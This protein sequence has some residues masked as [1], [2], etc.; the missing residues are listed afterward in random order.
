MHIHGRIIGVHYCWFPAL[1]KKKAMFSVPVSTPHEGTIAVASSLADLIM[2]KASAYWTWQGIWKHR[3]LRLIFT[4][5]GTKSVCS[6]SLARR[7]WSDGKARDRDMQCWLW[8]VVLQW[9]SR[10]HR[11]I[12]TIIQLILQDEW[13][14]I[15][16]TTQIINNFEK[17]SI[18]NGKDW[19][20]M[21][22]TMLL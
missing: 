15:Y 6:Y 17:M 14:F 13:T 16:F 18:T 11:W 8:L 3:I 4:W 7:R 9:C 5:F 19:H 10:W 1:L 12:F 2:L 20:C 22:F 21:S